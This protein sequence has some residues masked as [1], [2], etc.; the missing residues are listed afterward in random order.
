M[1]IETNTSKG[2]RRDE[3]I[4]RWQ[5]REQENFSLKTKQKKKN[6]AQQAERTQWKYIYAVIKTMEEEWK[7]IC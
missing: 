2:N 5:L 1:K 3:L 4:L 7:D 6:I